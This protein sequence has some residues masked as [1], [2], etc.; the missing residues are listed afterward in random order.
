MSFTDLR[1][2]GVPA[3]PR[4]WL[5]ACLAASAYCNLTPAA[6]VPQACP[7]AG[8]ASTTCTEPE[9]GDWETWRPVLGNKPGNSYTSE[10]AALKDAIAV[11]SKTYACGLSYAMVDAPY[12]E[13]SRVL[14][15]TAKE[16]AARITFVGFAGDA[17]GHCWAGTT[18]ASGYVFIRRERRVRCPRGYGWLM[19]DDQPT[20]CV[21]D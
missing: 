4:K 21:K 3:K 1:L 20:I 12:T 16:D 13:S 14:L 19:R 5:L 15:W 17:V 2:P 18:Q 8:T 6:A 7:D 11:L 10:D 9:V